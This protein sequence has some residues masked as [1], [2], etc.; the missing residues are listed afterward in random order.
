MRQETW[1]GEK[2]SRVSTEPVTTTIG[3]SEAEALALDAADPLAP[4]R[5]RFHLLPGRIYLDGNSLGLLSRDA[6]AETLRALEQWKT[7]GIDGWLGADPPWFTLGEEL[8]ALV[9]PLIGAEPEAVV[10]TGSTTVNQH[11]LTATFYR[12]HG[13]GERLWP[14]R[15]ISPPTS[16]PCRA[17]SAS[18]AAIPSATSFLSPP[19]TGARSKKTT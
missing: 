16:T 1:R 8:G 3:G 12:P 6:E 2:R 10:V 4:F 18:T 9:A 7:L 5:E 17:S 15:S 13:R 14:P 11:A 19:A